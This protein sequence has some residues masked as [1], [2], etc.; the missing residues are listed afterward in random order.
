VGI[1]QGGTGV[2]PSFCLGGLV[3]FGFSSLSF[4]LAILSFTS[5]FLFTAYLVI[6]LTF[7]IDLNV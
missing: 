6:E 3:D 5:L 7:H 4:D 1:S 2:S